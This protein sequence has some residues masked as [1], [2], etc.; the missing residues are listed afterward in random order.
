M[1]T[2]ADGTAY[3]YPQRVLVGTRSKNSTQEWESARELKYSIELIL[4]CSKA[5][6]GLGKPRE[7]AR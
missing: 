2:M 1:W 5:T 7:T 4:D 6:C 3:V